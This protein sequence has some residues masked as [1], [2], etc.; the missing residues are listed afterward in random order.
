MVMFHLRRIALV[1]VALFLAQ[2]V[3]AADE[4]KSLDLTVLGPDN[5]PVVAK[6]NVY[7]DGC[8]PSAKP[9]TDAQ[10]LAKIEYPAKVPYLNVAVDGGKATVP[11]RLT[12]GQ[13]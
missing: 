5:K 3:I 7:Y 8:D 2:P 12:W 1:V 13:G 4:K 10:G 11:M 6:L 9:T